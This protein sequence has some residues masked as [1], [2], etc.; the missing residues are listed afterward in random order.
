M[1]L[2]VPPK[3]VKKIEAELK[4]RREHFYCIGHVESAPAGK[5][6][7]SFAGTLPIN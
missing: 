7:V 3:N 6:R 4:R 2:V 1:I 5:S